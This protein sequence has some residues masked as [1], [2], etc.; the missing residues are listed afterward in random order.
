MENVTLTADVQTAVD[1]ILARSNQ[2]SGAYTL[3]PS[4]LGVSATW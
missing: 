3:Q 4:A 2:A 1:K